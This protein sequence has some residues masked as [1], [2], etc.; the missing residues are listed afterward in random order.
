MPCDCCK[1]KG[2]PMKCNYCPGQFC[3]KCLKL[4]AHKCPGESLKK[5]KEL[6]KLEKQ[7]EYAPKRKVDVI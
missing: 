1:K 2:I 6:G 4:D 3:T 5:E 7:L